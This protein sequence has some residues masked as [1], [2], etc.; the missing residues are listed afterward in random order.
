MMID[1]SIKNIIRG[2]KKSLLFLLLI[3]LIALFFISSVVLAVNMK[4]Y[5]EKTYASYRSIGLFEYIG[6]AYPDETVFSEDV[7]AAAADLNALC[8]DA[9]PRV[10]QWDTPVKAVGYH[11]AITRNDQDIPFYENAVLL[12]KTGAKKGDP[13]YWYV[14]VEQELYSVRDM[15]GKRIK[16]DSMTLPLELNHYYLVNGYYQVEGMPLPILY[17]HSFEN[18]TAKASG[19]DGDIE[20]MIVDVTTSDGGYAIPEDCPLLSIA[21]TYRVANDGLDVYY[22]ADVESLL[23]FEQ[24]TLYLIDGRFFTA[25]EYANG[26]AVCIITEWVAERLGVGVGDSVP[27]SV[28][29]DPRCASAQ[30]YWYETGF[31]TEKTYTV[32]GITNASEGS[33]HTVFAPKAADTPQ[34]GSFTY[35]LGIARLDNDGAEAFYADVVPKLP[36]NVR[37]QIYDQGWNAVSEPLKSV[38]KTVVWL[39]ALSSVAMLTLA[40]VF[41]YLFVYSD[42]RSAQ[43]MTRLGTNRAKVYGHYLIGAGMIVVFAAALSV[44]L[45]MVLLPIIVASMDQAMT[46]TVAD[47]TLDYSNAALSF[48]RPLEPLPTPGIGLLLFGGGIVV[49]LSLLSCALFAYA[50]MKKP[51]QRREAVHH[52]SH[53]GKSASLSGG[54]FKYAALATVRGDARSFAPF[55]VVLLCTVML[56]GLAS[57][58]QT[59][60]EQLSAIRGNTKIKGVYT[61]LSGRRTDGLLVEAYQVNALSRTGMVEDVA[62]SMKKPF[63]YVGHIVKDGDTETIETTLSNGVT[64]QLLEKYTDLFN[65]D[66]LIFTND[67]SRHPTFGSREPVIHWLDGYD[68]SVFT[69]EVI[70]TET[71]MVPQPAVAKPPKG[72]AV[73]SDPVLVE[74]TEVVIPMVVPERFLEDR[75]VAV[76]DVVQF[77]QQA[78]AGGV[79][80]VKYRIV[81]SY[82]G[83]SGVNHLFCPLV[84]GIAPELLFS[85]ADEATE[86]LYPYTLENAQFTL[87]NSN[88]LHALKAFFLD[89][90][91]SEVRQIRKYR[92]FVVLNDSSFLYTTAQ[93]EKRIATI[94]SFYPLALGVGAAIAFIMVFLRRKEVVTMKLLG[95]K[96]LRA[97]LNL[98]LEQLILCATGVGIGLF[99]FWLF[100]HTLP[101]DGLRWILILASGYLLSAGLSAALILLTKLSSRSKEV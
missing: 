39:V 64:P 7:H 23:P 33:L 13:W 15:E 77:Q 88:D 73:S 89:A 71:R 74:Q 65:A 43:I 38:Q 37:L 30:S 25:E 81:G 17:V 1:F 34:A 4:Q 28:V 87:K 9:D 47:H 51:M 79:E 57:T 42:R 5:S 19:F 16:L 80:L 85:N 70:E 49:L 91:Y 20:Q 98:W 63:F 10:E 78:S 67:M 8:L 36:E 40:A 14:T 61:D 90:G 29:S 62:V 83:S 72:A 99:G 54:S 55:A 44:I 31:D 84:Y 24:E 50:A 69:S 48:A 6:G 97:W 32:V 22:T 92:S 41:G 96:Q 12:V 59:Y 3:V 18:A 2:W 93:L 82:H 11:P 52:R 101:T 46:G 68:N 60:T 27:L 94:P 66:K 76:G 35:T 58:K 56:L 75:A 21:Q 100:K 86:A 95:T 26:E 53:K 45:S